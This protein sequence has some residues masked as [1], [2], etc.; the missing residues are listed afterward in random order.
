MALTALIIEDLPNDR[1]VVEHLLRTYYSDKIQLVGMASTVESGLTLLEKMRPNL[2]F[3]DVELGDALSFQLF[4]MS[5]ALREAAIIFTTGHSRYVEH[6]F[7]MNA[8][9]YLLKPVGP[10]RFKKAVDKALSLP[11]L[12]IDVIQAIPSLLRTEPPPNPR[13][14]LRS[15]RESWFVHLY[16]VVLAE[17][18]TTCCKLKFFQPDGKLQDFLSSNNLGEYEKLWKPYTYIYRLSRRHLVNL[19]HAL[20]ITYNAGDPVLHL[21]GGQ[22]VS[23][24]NGKVREVEQAILGIENL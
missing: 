12:P 15:Q 6:A 1:E 5:S 20:R 4:D 24:P 3:L 9:D 7:E 18:D 17:A 19:R 11:P 14:V 13:L 21:S 22:A 10:D 8:L 23:I 16:D 2:V